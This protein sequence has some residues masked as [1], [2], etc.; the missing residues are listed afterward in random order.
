VHERDA[1]LRTSG[2]RIRYRVAGSGPAIVLAHGW[3]LD[4][5][6]WAPQFALL[7]ARLRV[8]AFDRRGFGLSVGEPDA[9]RDVDDLRVLLDA[10]SVD[11]AAIV[12]MSQGARLALAFAASAPERVSCL[13]LDG[14]PRLDAPGTDASS[15][16]V[17]IARFRELAARGELDA[18][19][20]EWV[21]HPLMKLRTN[22][23]GARALLRE[24][25]ARYPGRDLREDAPS[26]HT[27]A[28]VLR[29]LRA[30]AL[31]VNG[32]DDSAERRAAGAALTRALP[33]ARHALVAGAGHIP[34]LDAP[35]AYCEL[36]AEFIEMHARA[37]LG[38]TP[39][40][41]ARYAER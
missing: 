5:D 25:V 3:A 7:S 4:L 34:N 14:P 12:G 32:A 26:Q 19:R 36:L 28:L 41:A 10:L 30:P 39:P 15:A 23:G 33:A 2:A 20:A 9:E 6:M 29:S 8:I 27:S 18:V 37:P 13:V 40:R 24:M 17:P 31:V 16:D 1:Y 22:D 11:T 38:S 21:K 35:G